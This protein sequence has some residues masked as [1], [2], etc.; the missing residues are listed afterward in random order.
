MRKLVFAASAAMLG[1]SAPAFAQDAG[2]DGAP[3]T[4]NPEGTEMEAPDPDGNG[5]IVTRTETTGNGA[6]IFD[7]NG[8][9]VLDANGQPTFEQVVTGSMQT[10]ET[11]SGN[12]HTI[13]KTEG[14]HATVEHD[15]I[16]HQNAERFER[17]T[18]AERPERPEKPEKPEKPDRGGRP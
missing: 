3:D 10:V 2:D 14:E 1:L 17:Q 9:P 12:V 13:T 6:Q 8:D 11:P 16:N 4:E 5:A 7:A 15:R 18:R